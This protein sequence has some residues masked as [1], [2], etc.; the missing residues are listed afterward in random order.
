MK[1]LIISDIHGNLSALE[2]VLSNAKKRCDPDAVALLGDYIDYGLRSNEVVERLKAL[3]IPTVCRLWGNHEDAIL[4][5]NYGRFSSPRGVQSAKY[6]KSQ[7][8]NQTIEFLQS[9]EHKSGM[10]EF[11]LC[12]KRFL[13]V[14]GNLEDFYWKSIFPYSDLSGYE[15]YDYVLS[16]HS[17]YSHV[18]PI[19]FECENPLM[20][21]KK[22]TLFINPGSVGQ[23]RN[24][25]PRAQYAVLDFENG[26]FLNSVEYDVDCEMSLYGGEV[27]DFYRSRLE[28]G[29]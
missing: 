25:D 12:G 2:S 19:F 18:F 15:K 23:P 21:D 17:H 27:D 20:R 8:T 11:E 6:T 28:K 14:H 7:L 10:A 3:E 13:A 4:N 22:R 16:G 24:H 9:M 5:D 1:L 26:V 29:I